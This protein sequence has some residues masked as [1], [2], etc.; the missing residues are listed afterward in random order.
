MQPS[1]SIPLLAFTLLMGSP[2][3]SRTS[4]P[5][6]SP[7]SGN[8]TR[9]TCA[10]SN[11]RYSGWCHVTEELP[12]A[13]TPEGVCQNVLSCLNTVSCIKTYCNSTEIRSGWRLEKVETDADSALDPALLGGY[14]RSDI[15]PF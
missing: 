4:A 9:V 1:R 8:A 11:P 6:R 3:S 14:I 12:D 7:A 5:S 13:S 15:D 2:F 10:F